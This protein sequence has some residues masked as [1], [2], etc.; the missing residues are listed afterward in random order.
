V[1]SV[2]KRLAIIGGVLSA[3][4]FIATL[5]RPADASGW[6]PLIV[7]AANAAVAFIWVWLFLPVVAYLGSLVLKAIGMALRWATRP[8]PRTAHAEKG[9]EPRSSGDLPVR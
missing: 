7:A 4:V 5:V 8:M 2:T 6:P 1:R 9:E 3:I